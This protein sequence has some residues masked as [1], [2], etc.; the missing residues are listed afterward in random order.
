MPRRNGKPGSAAFAL[1]MFGGSLVFLGS[2]RFD[3]FAS[4]LFMLLCIA[5]LWL[6][7]LRVGQRILARWHGVKARA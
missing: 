2:D 5:G 1:A 4:A 7:A 6:G 3:T